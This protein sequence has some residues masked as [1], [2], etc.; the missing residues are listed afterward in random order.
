MIPFLIV[1][2][3]ILIV[4][5]MLIPTKESDKNEI[6]KKSN[7]GFGKDKSTDDDFATS[8]ALGAAGGLGAGLAGGNAAG[9]MLGSMTHDSFSNGL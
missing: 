6:T 4:V 1:L 8:F 3:V 5:A 2:C 9:A 7:E